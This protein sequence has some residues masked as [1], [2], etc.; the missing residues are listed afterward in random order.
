M[1]I[2]LSDKKKLIMMLNEKRKLYMNDIRNC[3]F[4]DCPPK[5]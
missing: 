3:S 1:R 2:V 4:G 5:C